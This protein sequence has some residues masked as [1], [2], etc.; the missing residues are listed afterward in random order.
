MNQ[1]VAFNKAFKQRKSG[2]WTLPDVNELIT[3]ELHWNYKV[4]FWDEK[5]RLINQQ[6]VQ[7]LV[8]REGVGPLGLLGV[9]FKSATQKTT[10]YVTQFK[11]NTTP[12]TTQTAATPVYTEIVYT[13]DA[14][15]SVRPTLTLGSVSSGADLTTVD[16]SASKAVFNMLTTITLYGLAV[17]SVSSG[18]SGTDQLYGT[19]LYSPSQAVQNGYEVDVQATLSITAG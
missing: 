14:S 6:N 13:T 1:V 8:T 15:Q 7:N 9:M 16:N 18:G 10:W 5:H 2:I 19:V 11:T 4:N 3:R 17:I 12:A